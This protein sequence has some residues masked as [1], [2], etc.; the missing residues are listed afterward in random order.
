MTCRMARVTDPYPTRTGRFL[1]AVVVLA[2]LAAGVVPH[3]RAQDDL[4]ARAEQAWR[5]ER[6][7]D[8]IELYREIVRSSPEDLFSKKRLALLLSWNDR[9]EES[10]ALYREILEASPRDEEAKQ[11]LA[12]VLSWHGRYREARRGYLDLISRHERVADASLG[13]GDLSLWEGDLWGAERWYERALAADP[14]DTRARVG[15]ARAWHAQGLTKQ[16]LGELDGIPAGSSGAKDADRVRERIGVDT[17]TSVSVSHT[18][19]SD[20]D[21]ND[22]DT[23]RVSGTVFTD[24]QSTV[25]AAY[26]RD[27]AESNCGFTSLCAPGGVLVQGQR[28]GNHADRVL[29]SYRSRIRTGF[30]VSGRAGLV[31]RSLF[32]GG[33]STGV[34]GGAELTLHPDADLSYGFAV[35]FEPILSTAP[36]IENEIRF[37][38]LSGNASHA[39]A[40]RWHVRGEV[41]RSWINDDN[42]RLAAFGSIGVRLPFGHPRTR[43]VFSSRALRYDDSPET[44][45]FS[46]ELLWTNLVTASI[47]DE[48]RRRRLYYAVDL[49]LGVQ[50]VRLH[51]VGLDPGDTGDRGTD[52]VFGWNLLAGANL[53]D[54]FSIEA[55]Y[56]ESDMAQQTATGFEYRQAFLQLRAEW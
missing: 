55:S 24:P 48:T 50:E 18:S 11:E 6:H 5:E 15:L 4:R 19:Y 25:T 30:S 47:A 21:D 44:G 33:S 29:A 3:S 32:A 23:E 35:S 17:R 36:L 10:I 45:Y 9:L 2:A 1:A 56:G 43:V 42:G 52:R 7:A 12:K 41:S 26:V 49:S 38:T 20:T 31:R 22:L 34:E 51:E 37:D 53:S 8:A 46:P 16:A 39:F 14:S 28:F 54:H 40:E 13:L 27:E